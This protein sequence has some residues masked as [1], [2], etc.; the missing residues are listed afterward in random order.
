ML[1]SRS[2][3]TNMR[4][5]A[6]G[7]SLGDRSKKIAIRGLGTNRLLGD[8]LHVPQLS[9]GLVSVRALDKHKYSTTFEH[10]RCVCTEIASRKTIFTATLLT[11]SISLMNPIYP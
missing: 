11:I 2:Q 3:L 9:F 10:N 1:P 5:R 8:T 7:V 4:P 6:G